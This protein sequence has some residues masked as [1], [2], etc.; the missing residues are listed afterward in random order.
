LLR[1]QLRCVCAQGCGTQEQKGGAPGC[2]HACAVT[3]ANARHAARC[4]TH[5]VTAQQIQA[6]VDEAVAS[7]MQEL[8][9]E[10]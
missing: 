8:L 5:Q 1:G 9:E 10:R 4:L 3:L 7:R 2:A 6:A